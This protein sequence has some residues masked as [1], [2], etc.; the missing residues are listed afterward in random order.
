M[1]RFAARAGIRRTDYQGRAII[2]DALLGPVEDP[3][4]EAAP[5]ALSA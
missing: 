2:L 4:L 5:E 1:R 3:E